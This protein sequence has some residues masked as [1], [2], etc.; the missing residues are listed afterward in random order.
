MLSTT[1]RRSP[2]QGTALSIRKEVHNA[3]ASNAPEQYPN[4]IRSAL[5]EVFASTRKRLDIMAGQKRTRAGEPKSQSVPQNAPSQ[6]TPT[7][8]TPPCGQAQP[9]SSKTST[10]AAPKDAQTTSSQPKEKKKPR[11][12]ATAKNTYVPHIH[13]PLK[14][15]AQ[16]PHNATITKRPLLHPAI[17]TPFASAENPKVLYITAS[18]PFIPTCK[19]IRSLLVQISKRATQAAS[20]G[21]RRGKGAARKLEAN[22]R[23]DPKDVEASIAETAQQR[24]G[25]SVGVGGEEV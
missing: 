21:R 7:T 13:G 16:L 19:R 24:K 15:R 22:G 5:L 23:L 11:T 8:S 10:S 12:K 3:P 25:K 17:P 20:E 14:K 2:R 6:S 9:A 4:Q 1:H 18:S